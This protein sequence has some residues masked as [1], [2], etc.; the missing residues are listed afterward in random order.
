MTPEEIRKMMPRDTENGPF[1]LACVML[2]EIAAHLA[3]QSNILYDLFNELQ[4]H[5]RRQS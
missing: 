4:N 2:Q 1:L 5:Y 3:E